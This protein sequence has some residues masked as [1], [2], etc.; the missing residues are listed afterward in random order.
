MSMSEQEA[1]A[2]AIEAVQR[3]AQAVI[4]ASSEDAHEAVHE[5]LAT[6]EAVLRRV[7]VEVTEIPCGFQMDQC[8][9]ALPRGHGGLHECRRHRF[10]DRSLAALGGGNHAE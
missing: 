7:P 2:E 10:S 1:Q 9:C 5:D 6:V 8:R 3:L 4:N